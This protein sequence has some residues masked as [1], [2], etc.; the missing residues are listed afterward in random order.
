M[1]LVD[2]ADPP[3]DLVDLSRAIRRSSNFSFASVFFQYDDANPT[4][5][6]GAL[7]V[8][9]AIVETPAFERSLRE[10]WVADYRKT[11]EVGR[12]EKHAVL[13]PAEGHLENVLASA[14]LDQAGAYSRA[15]RDAT[16]PQRDE[17]AALF[18]HLGDYL[19]FELVS[20]PD[21]ACR[22]CGYNS[23]LFSTWFYGVAWDWCF[24]VVWPAAK[25]AGVVCLTDT[26]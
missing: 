22:T 4:S 10:T 13:V 19:A 16:G 3:I 7:A 2:L 21:P 15:V 1:Q 11:L 12:R 23:H 20:R 25:V 6:R 8:F 26:D 18:R 17:V 5:L 24:F 14:S 9:D